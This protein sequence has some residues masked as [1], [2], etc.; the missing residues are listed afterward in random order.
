MTQEVREEEE[1]APRSVTAHDV[2]RKHEKTIP[3]VV[4]SVS[5]ACSEDA[6]NDKI[7]AGSIIFRKSGSTPKGRKRYFAYAILFWIAEFVIVWYLKKCG[8]LKK[9]FRFDTAVKDTVL[10]Q[11]EMMRTRLNESIPLSYL[12]QEKK[13]PGYQL[14]SKGAVAKYPVVIVPGFVTSGLEVWAGKDC[15]KKHFRQRLWAALGG[16]RSFLTDRECWAEHMR[17]NLTTGSDVDGIRLRAAEGF[18]AA[19]YFMA[20]Y[21]VFGKI[22]ENLAD[23]GYSTSNMVMMPYDWR[24]EYSLLEARDGYF[25]QLANS[26]ERLHHVQG[27]KVV[28]VTHSMGALVCHYFFAWVTSNTAKGGGGRGRRW[29][30]KHVHS[31]VNLAG[32]HLGVPKAASA[33]LSGEMSDTAFIGTME[34]MVEQFFGRKSRRDLWL[35]WG[36][37]WSMLPKGQRLWETGVDFCNVRSIDDL[38]CPPVGPSAIIATTD[39]LKTRT[40]GVKSF[41]NHTKLFKEALSTFL[42]QPSH[43]IHDTIQFIMNYGTGQNSGLY[44]AEHISYFGEE[45]PSARTWHDPTRTPLP[46][47]PNLKIYCIYG[48]GVDTERAYFYKRNKDDGVEG[49]VGGL[50]DPPLILDTSF[51]NETLKTEYGVRYSDGDGSVPLLSLGYICTEAWRNKKVGLNPSSTVVY[52]REYEH[53]SEFHVDDMMRGGPRSAEHVDVLGHED[54][55]FDLLRIVSDFEVS[56]I[57]RDII[58]SNIK[59]IA[60]NISHT[61]PIRHPKRW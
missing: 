30:D 1:D 53:R 25:T 3:R 28:L 10:P 52:T 5:S 2:H 17:L 48:V 8:V 34:N 19:D 56:D 39:S 44:N 45:K 14:A 12:T 21:W 54:V 36:S 35:S 27:R 43:S 29:V 13:R 24:L 6:S 20:N 61:A 7:D 46:F 42:E 59:E 15:A 51:S 47:A 37:V 31:Y 18:N 11:L 50:L 55:L 32:S 4:T 16:A 38:H 41:G 33:L 9:E 40:E 58:I 60:A 22:I 57:E 23:L 26:I 49:D